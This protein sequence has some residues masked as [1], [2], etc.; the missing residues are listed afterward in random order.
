MMPSILDSILASTRAR[1]NKEIE[2]TPIKK[3]EQSSHFQAP[4]VSLKKYLQRSDLV[5]IIAEIKRKSPSKGMINEFCNVAELSLGYMQAGASALSI[6]TE[7]QYFSGSLEDLVT[8]RRYNFCPILRKDFIIDE[9]Q[10]IEAR[11]FGADVILLIA[12]ALSVE[13]VRRFAKLARSLGLEILLEIHSETELEYIDSDI[14][15]VGINNRDLKDFSVDVDRSFLL[16]SK[17]PKSIMTISESGLRDPKVVSQLRQHG[18]SGFLIGEAFMMH[19]NPA[20]ACRSY[21]SQLRLIHGQS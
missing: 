1:V 18:F 14:D 8:T 3:L 4:T 7:P 21:I 11:A 20:Q 9:Y 6:L 2:V 15:L 16:R 12:A 13:Q 17:I 5:G 19:A 10:I